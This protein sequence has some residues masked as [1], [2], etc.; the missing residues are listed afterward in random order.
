MA[1]MRWYNTVVRIPDGSIIIIGGSTAGGWINNA[2]QNNP[3][4]EF[5][6]PK[7]NGLPVPLQFLKDTLNSNLFPIAFS[8]PDGRMFMAANRDAMIYD[9][10]SKS[11]QRLP[12]IPNGVRVTYPMT[13]VGLLLPLDPANNYAAEILI[14]G[15]STMNDLKP[16]DEETSQYPSSS[17]CARMMLNDKGIAKGWIVEHMPQARVMPDAVLLPTGDVFIVNGG[18]SGIAGYGNL[19]HQVGQSNA[20]HPVFTPVLYNPTAQIDSRFSSNGL[21]TSNIPRLY[22]SSATLLPDGHVLVA[23]SNPNLDRSTVMY[24]TEYRVE[25][26]YP[27]YMNATRPSIINCPMK[28]EFNQSYNMQVR[29]PDDISPNTVKG[30]YIYLFFKI[31]VLIRPLVSLMDFGFST[32]AVHANSRLVY[33]QTKLSQD[34]QTLTVKAPP[35]GNIYP[36]G[37]GFVFVVA[38]NVPSTSVMVMIGDGQGPP[39]DESAIENLLNNS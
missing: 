10:Q 5:F 36:P 38:D 19:Q 33:L 26:F 34:Q 20:D 14:C 2:T 22:H 32:H 30:T 15:G 11:E 9:W 31:F 24:Q 13:G 16:P 18:G 17:Q 6:P 4:Y 7:D 3:T 12:Q 28:M 25:H 23:G 35:N 8:L 37:P 29:L 39:V 21:P 1:S 27:P